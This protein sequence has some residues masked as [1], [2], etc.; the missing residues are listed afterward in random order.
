LSYVVKNTSISL[1]SPA[2]FDGH[3]CVKGDIEVSS[4]VRRPL[5]PID[6]V[7]TSCPEGEQPLE[8]EPPLE[9]DNNFVPN[10]PSPM[11]HPCVPWGEG[12]DAL[13]EFGCGLPPPILDYNGE[14]ACG[15]PPWFNGQDCFMGMM[16]DPSFG[17]YDGYGC[18]MPFMPG[19]MDGLEGEQ[20]PGEGCF[21]FGDEQFGSN[22][23]QGRTVV[24]L[25]EALS[26]K[27]QG[28][29]DPE[30]SAHAKSLADW[31]GEMEIAMG[32]HWGGEQ[33]MGAVGSAP[34]GKFPPAAPEQA[35]GHASGD[36]ST[37]QGCS[38]DELQSDCFT[39]S[40]IEKT[41]EEGYAT[42]KVQES[43]DKG[44]QDSAYTTVMLRNIPN[45]YTRDMLVDQL[46]ALNGEFDFIYMPIDFRNG[47]N[48]GYAFINFCSSEARKRFVANF[49]GVEVCRCLPGLNSRKVAEV[50]PASI[51]GLKMNVQRLR[52]SPVMGKL[53][54]HPEWMPLLF[55]E[56]GG[57]LTFPSPEQP[58]AAVKHRRCNGRDA[59]TLRRQSS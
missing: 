33:D 42:S 23:E 1:P 57:L 54:Y 48:V 16:Y 34:D 49:H 7:S 5:S 45:K 4:L 30:A 19:S 9:G 43:T 44:D 11:M 35:C 27:L 40:S 21:A 31:E 2:D 53:I 26:E 56:A 59:A 52:N 55:D 39:E 29:K 8:G 22:S 38:W 50:T 46:Q 13:M 36:S 51:Q 47:C 15:V 6:D 24:T 20:M 14:S 10:T 17:A 41:W 25:L 12:C 28:S 3:N 18:Y 32:E 37:E 58:L